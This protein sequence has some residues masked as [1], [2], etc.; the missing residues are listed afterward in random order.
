MKQSSSELEPGEKE[1]FFLLLMENADI[2]AISKSDLGR[3]NTFRHYIN[4]GTGNAPHP[5]DRLFIHSLQ[6]LL[7]GMLQNGVVQP[8]S[9]PWA[10]PIVLVRKKDNG[11]RFCV[12]YRKL[13]DVTRKDE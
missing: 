9:S 8:T 13:N 6:E 11:Y 10:F 5:S 1:Q 3:T 12:D 7:D 4:T 2:F